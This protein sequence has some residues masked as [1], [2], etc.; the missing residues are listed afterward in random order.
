LGRNVLEISEDKMNQAKGLLAKLQNE[1]VQSENELP[2]AFGGKVKFQP[3]E[4]PVEVT[5]SMVN[6]Q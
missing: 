6:V 3:I 1:E 5:P 4:N 2:M